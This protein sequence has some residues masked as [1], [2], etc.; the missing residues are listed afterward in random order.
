[1]TID[2]KLKI[3][4][5]RKELCDLMLACSAVNAG[6][7]YKAQKWQRLHDDLKQLIDRHDEIVYGKIMKESSD[8]S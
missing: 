6:N 4:M 8:D 2:K 5:T 3:T 7:K 1:M